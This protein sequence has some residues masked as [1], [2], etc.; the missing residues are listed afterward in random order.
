MTAISALLAFMFGSIPFSWI[1]VR[2]MRGVDIRTVGSGNPG[3]TNAWRVMGAKWGTLALALDIAKGLLAV[4]VAPLLT[5]NP[6]PEWLGALCG[7]SAI[8]GNVF[9]P[10]LKFKGGKAVATATG[11]FLALTPI[12]V[13]LVLTVFAGL[14]AWTRKISVGSLAGSI[15]L[16]LVITVEF[17]TSQL[18]APNSSVLILVWS[19]AVLVVIR[20]VPNIRRLLRG[21]EKTFF[22]KGP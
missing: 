14:V 8:L 1:L 3:A 18:D 19:A 17:S 16:P 10:F 22:K 5:A 13:L 4:L 20:H 21:E 12:A 11:V 6:R 9:C 15:L 2:V 7:C